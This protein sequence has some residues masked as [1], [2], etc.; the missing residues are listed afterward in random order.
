M[1]RQNLLRV[2]SLALQTVIRSYQLLVSPLLLPSCRFL[3]SCSEYAAEAIE[4]HGALR[5]VGLALH[6]FARC[7]PWGGSGFDPVP[8][9]GGVDRL[10][11]GSRR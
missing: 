4:R 10:C 11:I 6:R 5:G 3:P 9:P 8:E 7:H 1:E 2:L